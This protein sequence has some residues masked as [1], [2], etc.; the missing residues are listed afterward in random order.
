MLC[1]DNRGSLT[2][3]SIVVTPNIG[4]TV[5]QV[6]FKDEGGTPVFISLRTTVGELRLV[7]VVQVDYDV[8]AGRPAGV[9]A[10]T[11][12]SHRPCIRL[13]DVEQVHRDGGIDL[14]EDGLT[15]AGG[16][17]VERIVSATSRKKYCEPTSSR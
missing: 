2:M 14:D 9:P 12:G 11:I 3:M 6:G 13:R 15:D 4:I 5:G 1:A 16:V 10:M 7:G 17:Q 8:N